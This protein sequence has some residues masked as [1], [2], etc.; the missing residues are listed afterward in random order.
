MK[1][2]C[3]IHALTLA[4]MAIGGTQAQSPSGS[5]V[6]VAVEN[7][8]RAES[9]LYFRGFVNQGGFGK[10]F[11]LGEL[12][13]AN[14]R[15][16]IRPNRDTLYSGAVFDLN[17]GP[18][19]ISLPDAGNR[20]ISMQVIDEDNFTQAVV[21]GVGSY[22]FSREKTDT[23]YI[24]A[25]MRTL[26]DPTSPKDL[27]EVHALQDAIK[28]SQKSP[29]RFEVPNWDQ[30]SGKKVHDALLVLGETVPDTKRMFGNRVN[31]DPVRHLIG[32][33]IL[34]GSLP[35][36]DAFY[37]NLTP[38]K[39]DGPTTHRLSVKDVPVD[40][41]WSVSVYNAEGY[42]QPNQYNAYTLNNVTA[43]KGT[44]GSVTI[45][46][47]GCDGKIANCLP[48]MPRWNYAVR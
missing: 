19:T 6:P 9:D 33:A 22:T 30:A 37:L 24:I 15:G 34:W 1:M 4:L 16:V 23:R 28:V 44:D 26:V 46:F 47:G 32:T 7:F 17:A 29:S 14:L 38:D 5:A 27:E 25:F 13:P 3:L 18:V 39:N 20:Y 35:E 31:V 12:V 45:Q 42:F 36:K 2:N 48:T 10:F 8:A 21:Y 41:F 40:G 43:T 11:H